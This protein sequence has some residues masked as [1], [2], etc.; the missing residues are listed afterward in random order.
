M[1]QDIFSVTIGPGRNENSCDYCGDSPTLKKVFRGDASDADRRYQNSLRWD[2]ELRRCSVRSP[3]IVRSDRRGR[4][5]W[6]QWIDSK[7]S[8]QDMLFQ[9]SWEELVPYVQSAVD[10][11][12][13]IHELPISANIVL[14]RS[15]SPILHL[16][17]FLTKD[18]YVASSGAELEFY[19]LMQHDAALVNSLTNWEMNANRLP[20]SMI[21][22][23]F[24]LDQILVD[25]DSRAWIIDFEEYGFGASLKDFAG[26][27]GSLIFAALLRTFSNAPRDADSVDAIN[28]AF[29]KQG[30]NNLSVVCPLAVQAARRYLQMGQLNDWRDLSVLTGIFILERITSRAKLSYKLS[31]VDKAIAGIGRALILNPQALKQ[32]IDNVQ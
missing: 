12:A 15:M 32:V 3:R 4:I 1:Q 13:A 20:V 2:K 7:G 22:G 16:C 6:Y 5:I 28:A 17:H 18:E 8:L 26:L 29:L 11:L 27:I 23:D 31:E 25:D 10:D 9:K 30:D 14:Q 19:A 24:R 21:H